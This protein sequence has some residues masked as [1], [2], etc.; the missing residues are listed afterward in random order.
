M[1]TSLLPAGCSLVYFGRFYLA[2]AADSR[3]LDG[4]TEK[5]DHSRGSHR[6]W[7]D[8][9]DYII[10][11]AD[12]AVRRSARLAAPELRTALCPLS[13]ICCFQCLADVW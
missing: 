11:L 6:V 2:S 9:R 5:Q 3:V 4:K 8:H 1:F 10:Q 12:R 7:I 13:D